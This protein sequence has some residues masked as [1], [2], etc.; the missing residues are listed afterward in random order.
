MKLLVLVLYASA[1][2]LASHIKIS[3]GKLRL[4]FLFTRSTNYCV[5]LDIP[6]TLSGATADL[7]SFVA[8]PI[9]NDPANGSTSKLLFLSYKFL[10]IS[11]IMKTCTFGFLLSLTA[12]F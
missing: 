2:L 7:S 11:N 1:Y 4:P 3:S 9:N 8:K 5:Y 10:H 12:K 6:L